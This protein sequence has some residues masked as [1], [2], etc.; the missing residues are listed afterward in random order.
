MNYLKLFED[1]IANNIEGSLIKVDDVIECI[2]KNGLL[3]A[4]TIN[5]YPQHN[6]DE[7]LKVLDVDNEGLVTVEIDSQAHEVYLDNI[8]RLE[9]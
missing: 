9:F 4:E 1:F 2:N 6:P 7:G 5:D 3:Y 8:I